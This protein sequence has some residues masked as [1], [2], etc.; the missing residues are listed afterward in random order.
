MT[1]HLRAA[2]RDLEWMSRT[3]WVP[4]H[5]KQPGSRCFNLLWA[6]WPC[7]IQ[8]AK[9]FCW[10]N[11][12]HSSIVKPKSTKCFCMVLHPLIETH[13][14]AHTDIWWYLNTSVPAPAGHF[15]PHRG[16]QGSSNTV[17]KGPNPEHIQWQS[18]LTNAASKNKWKKRNT[19]AIYSIM[20]ALFV[21]VHSLQLHFPFFY[22]CFIPSLC[23]FL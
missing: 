14:R 22:F 21:A 1:Q 4:L 2:A 13:T 7:S 10:N 12:H 23:I 15:E 9:H 20:F 19:T 16:N 11:I 6:F 17:R 8:T 5:H 3:C 18:S